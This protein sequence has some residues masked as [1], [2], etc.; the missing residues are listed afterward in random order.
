MRTLLWLCA[1]A[2]IAWLFA[3]NIKTALPWYSKVYPNLTLPQ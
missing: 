2:G 3:T 1:V